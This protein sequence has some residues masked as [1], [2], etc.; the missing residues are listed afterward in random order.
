VILFDFLIESKAGCIRYQEKDL[1]AKIKCAHKALRTSCPRENMAR[2]NTHYITKAGDICRAE[3]L[4]HD[5]QH[6]VLRVST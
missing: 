1:Q 3:F 5:M 4:T 2:D 6:C